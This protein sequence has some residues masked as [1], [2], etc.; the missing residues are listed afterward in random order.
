[1]LASLRMGDFMDLRLLLLMV[2]AGIGFG[3]LLIHFLGGGLKRSILPDDESVKARFHL[4][5]PEIE[6]GEICYTDDHRTAFFLLRGAS[7][8]L[9]HSV[10]NRF[11]TRCVTAADVLTLEHKGDTELILHMK[12][13]TW[14]KARFL[15]SNA[16]DRERVISWLSGLSGEGSRHG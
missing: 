7:T 16:E 14:P 6:I 15:F 3:V 4:D 10:G 5:Y 1:M 13:F 2:V 8:G 11:L 9:V 12:D